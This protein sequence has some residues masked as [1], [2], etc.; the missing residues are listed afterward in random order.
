MKRIIL[1]AL[2]LVAGLC[3]PAFAN[4]EPVSD[5]RVFSV[6]CSVDGFTGEAR[7]NWAI[8][9]GL[10][11]VTLN[12]YRITRPHGKA[13]GNN[14]NVNFNTSNMTMNR[15]KAFSADNLIQDGEWHP[16]DLSA[17]VI[18]KES[19]KMREHVAFVFDRPGID[20]RCYKVQWHAV[21]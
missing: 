19:A 10:Y 2:P 5:S 8:S 14:A 3:S 4:T 6:S 21:W 20:P 16:L 18:W 12:R 9:D 13:V 7:F 1:W 11:T 15:A 17:S